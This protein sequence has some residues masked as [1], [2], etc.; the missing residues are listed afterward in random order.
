MPKDAILYAGC[1]STLT[2]NA[3]LFQ[4]VASNLDFSTIM[5]ILI[6][7]IFQFGSKYYYWLYFLLFTFIFKC[8]IIYCLFPGFL[9]W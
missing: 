6:F 5:Y 8:K 7:N 4:N 2:S 3:K 1:I 9:K